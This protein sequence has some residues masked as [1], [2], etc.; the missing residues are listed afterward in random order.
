MYK[1]LAEIDSQNAKIISRHIFGSFYGL[2]TWRA[3]IELSKLAPVNIRE[4][5]RAIGV[6]TECHEDM[7][8]VQPLSVQ[9]DVCTRL[10]TPWRPSRTLAP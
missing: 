5:D 9:K 6:Q 7:T 4:A 8:H 10:S 1:H 2:I 3:V